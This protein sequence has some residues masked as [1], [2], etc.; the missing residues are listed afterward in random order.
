MCVS[1]SPW[2]LFNMRVFFAAEIA[3]FERVGSAKGSQQQLKRMLS[4]GDKKLQRM[5][6][7]SESEK[8]DEKKVLS[9]N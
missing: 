1:W 5:R 2:L 6:S 9:F 8:K 4:D 3:E 7:V